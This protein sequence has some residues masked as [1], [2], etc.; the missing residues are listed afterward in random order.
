MLQ[1]KAAVSYCERQAQQ[2][3]NRKYFYNT[4][5]TVRTTRNNTPNLKKK[6][7]M[8]SPTKKEEGNEFALFEKETV[9]NDAGH[10]VELRRQHPVIADYLA[11]KKILEGLDTSAKMF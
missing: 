7:T 6:S 2:I 10:K 5:C 8:H 9:L 4:T 11:I 1:G 3:S